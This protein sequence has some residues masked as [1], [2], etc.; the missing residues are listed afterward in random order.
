M[1]SK[2]EKRKEQQLR[3]RPQRLKRQRQKRKERS[4]WWRGFRSSL[5]C[6]SC[7]MTDWRCLEFHHRDPATKK[8]NVSET[9]MFSF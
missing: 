7:G 2:G 6:V 5:A 8:F 3:Q 9:I 1:P 4:E